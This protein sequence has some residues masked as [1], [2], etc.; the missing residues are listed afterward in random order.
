[1][2]Y[3][4]RQIEKRL[5]QEYYQHQSV[6]ARYYDVQAEAMCSILAHEATHSKGIS[7]MCHAAAYLHDRQAYRRALRAPVNTQENNS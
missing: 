7:V 1:M 2:S 4:K 5:E 6:N 3:T